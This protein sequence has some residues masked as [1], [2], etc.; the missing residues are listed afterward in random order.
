MFWFAAAA[1]VLLA[2]LF[3]L[4]P[5]WKLHRSG[6]DSHARREHTN[7]LIFQERVAELETERAAGNLEDDSFIALKQELERS[8]LTDVEGAGVDRADS[9][10]K[11]GLWSASR[12]IPLVL[13]LAIGPSSAWF[14]HHWGYQEELALAQLY[15]RTTSNT[16]DPE[17]AKNLVYAIGDIIQEDNTNG[18]AWYFLAQNLVNLGQFPEA[19][20]SLERAGSLVEQPQ[21]KVVI[22]S[23]YAFLEY[24][25]ADQELTDKVQGIV[26]QVQRIDPNQVLVLQILSMDAER[27]SDYQSAITYWS[28]ILQLTPPGPD[29][30]LLRERIANAQ[31][32]LASNSASGD[33]VADGPTIDVELSLAPN[34]D[35]PPETRVF[36]SALQLNGRGQPLAAEVITVADLPTTVTLDNSDAVGP[37]NVG[38]AEMVYIVATASSS[39]TANV[40]AGDYQVKSEGFAHLNSHAIIQLVIQDQVAQDGP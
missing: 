22:L 27:S 25:L 35:L 33:T 39:G 9:S 32:M 10:A 13:V 17:E 18:W 23:Q 4:L 34:V 15:E 28:R 31:Q 8:L 24:M 3:V 19:S 26:D 6:G 21:D 7:L 20:I 37:F 11:A 12:L 1:L 16:D 36:V 30:D 14:Y 5:L 38:S 40:Q 2:I 29:S